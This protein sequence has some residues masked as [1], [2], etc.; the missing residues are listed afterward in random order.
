MFPFAPY[1]AGITPG[2]S[3]L[4]FDVPEVGRFGLTICYDMWFPETS[5]TLAWMGAEVI[6]HP[7]LTNTIDRD[8]ELAI[9]RATAA[10]NQCYFFDINGAGQLGVGQSIV[11]GPEGDV[12]HRAGSGDEIIPIELDFGRVRRSRER[13]LLGLGQPLKSFRDCG[14]DFPPYAH[15]QTTSM[16]LRQ[17]GPLQKP[18]APKRSEAGE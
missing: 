4:V 2:N 11:V 15:R 3:F 16:A 12:I 18:D 14:I 5:R 7:T 9:A 1:E 6:L 10:T 8:V 13:G 17:L